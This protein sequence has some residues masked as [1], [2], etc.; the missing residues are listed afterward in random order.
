MRPAACPA[1]TRPAPQV[2][3]HECDGP[4]EH[5]VHLPPDEAVVAALLPV[6]SKFTRKAAKKAAGGGGEA[7]LW[8]HLGE[9]QQGALAQLAVY[10]LRL[11]PGG[12]WL[13]QLSL[14]QPEHMWGLQLR[15]KD[16]VE[17]SLAVEGER[18]GRVGGGVR[19][20]AAALPGVPVKGPLPCLGALGSAARLRLLTCP[21][22]GRAHACRPGRHS[23]L[24]RQPGGPAAPDRLPAQPG[25]L[26]PRALRGRHG[27][28]HH[29]HG[30]QRDVR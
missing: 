3:V 16:V 18:R 14:H 6:R 5:S 28:G 17:Q 21:S 11:D 19:A 12:E 29:R 1:V 7:A 22:P 20:V 4:V 24:A 25:R 10:Y 13:G 27:A 15:S 9:A 30:G 2:V 8:E 26:L 23:A